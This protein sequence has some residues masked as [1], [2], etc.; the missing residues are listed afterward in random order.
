MESDNM[1]SFASFTWHS[2]SEVHVTVL[3]SFLWLDNGPLC[4]CTTFY[5]SSCQV[6][7][8]WVVSTFQQLWIMLLWTLMSTF[9]WEYMFSVLSG[10]HR[11]VKL[12]CHTAT[13]FLIHWSVAKL[14]SK[15]AAPFHI[16]TT[17]SEGSDCSTSSLH[18]LCALFLTTAILLGVKE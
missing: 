17:V 5:V 6:M 10:I 9:L 15:G 12:L 3:R 4:S 13:P 18:L 8:I 14:L 2:V 7:N 11:G 1:W 16:L